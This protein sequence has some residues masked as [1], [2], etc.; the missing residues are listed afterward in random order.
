MQI[1][2][3]I[4]PIILVVVVVLVGWWYSKPASTLSPDAAGVTA[5]DNAH[6]DAMT[7]NAEEI[8]QQQLVAAEA[9]AQYVGRQP[10]SEPVR[11]RPDFVSPLEWQVLQGV[12]AKSDTPD[13]TLMALVNH[14]LYA[15]QYEAWQSLDDK[16]QADRRQELARQLLNEIPALVDDETMSLSEAQQVQHEL[17]ASLYRDLNVLRQHEAKEAERIGVTFRIQSSDDMNN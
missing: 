16:T 14:L 1:R 4:T 3:W 11:Q 15:K 17:L 8:R 6:A 10:F 5:T 13:Q 2:K 9:A 12:A 7:G